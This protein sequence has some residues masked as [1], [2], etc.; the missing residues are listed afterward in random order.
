M[1]SW[2]NAAFDL[3]AVRTVKGQPKLSDQRC[4]TAGRGVEELSW[5]TYFIRCSNRHVMSPCAVNFLDPQRISKVARTKPSEQSDLRSRVL[6]T[7]PRY[8]VLKSEFW[9]SR[10]LAVV[11]AF[12]PQVPSASLCHSAI[13]LKDV[14]TA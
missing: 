2:L 7:L 3:T 9:A 11:V 12:V 6:P 14:T 5:K 8:G 10:A 13:L 4:V 1:T